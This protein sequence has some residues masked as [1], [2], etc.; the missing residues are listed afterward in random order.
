MVQGEEIYEKVRGGLFDKLCE[1]STL[2][3]TFESL[4]ADKQTVEWMNKHA[5][6]FFAQHQILLVDKLFLELA[7]LFDPASQGK[8]ERKLQNLS[9]PQLMQVSCLDPDEVLRVEEQFALAKNA[10]G[11]IPQLRN[12]VLAH[13][14]LDHSGKLVSE[15]LETMKNAFRHAKKVFDLCCTSKVYHRVLPNIYP[16]K[17]VANLVRNMHV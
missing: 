8:G 2:L 4:Y 14:D 9:L 5:A 13:N 6:A 10:L 11:R 17:S 12:K 7:K 15:S 3:Y 1:I 16:A